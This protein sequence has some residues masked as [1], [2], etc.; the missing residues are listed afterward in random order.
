M[1]GEHAPQTRISERVG[2]I[3]Q[4]DTSPFVALARE[5][6]HG[7][8]ADDD[9]SIDRACQMHTEK[10]QSG[11]GNRIDQMGYQMWLRRAETEIFATE[12]DDA[13]LRVEAGEPRQ[14]IRLQS[15]AGDEM[16]GPQHLAGRGGDRNLSGRFANR[17]HLEAEVQLD[18]SPLELRAERR[19]N[20]P[21]IDDSGLSYPKR[22]DTADVRFERTQPLTR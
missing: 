20:L 7:I 16:R 17:A 9:A 12:R 8:R 18:A 14:P 6:Q 13:D 4:V 19:A 5:C 10:G 2:D 22:G 11:I 21:V 1:G 3:P 15:G